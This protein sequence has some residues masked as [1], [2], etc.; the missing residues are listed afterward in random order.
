MRLAR[1]RPPPGECP[2]S[3]AAHHELGGLEDKR[4]GVLLWRTAQDAEDDPALQ[5]ETDAEM[6]RENTN[7]PS[8]SLA[9][10][11]DGQL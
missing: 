10:C 3:G 1:L 8:A 9:S 2:G 4:V 6:G 5:R 7:G 11:C